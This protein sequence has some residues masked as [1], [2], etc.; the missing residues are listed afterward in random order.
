M[1]IAMCLVCVCVCVC[2]NCELYHVLCF[3][4]ANFQLYNKRT[5]W[6]GLFRWAF[7]FCMLATDVFSGPYATH[8]ELV[9]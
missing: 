7:K 6:T 5:E 2:T 3:V 1:K 9:R 8:L 4:C